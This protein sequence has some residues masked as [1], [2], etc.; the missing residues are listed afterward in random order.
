MSE[1]GD[2][3]LLSAVVLLRDV[4]VISVLVRHDG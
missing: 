3:Y 2:R 4:V 1:G